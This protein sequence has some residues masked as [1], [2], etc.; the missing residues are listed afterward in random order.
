MQATTSSHN[1]QLKKQKSQLSMVLRE[2]AGPSQ[3]VPGQ[4][5]SS[6]IGTAK[7]QRNPVLKKQML[8]SGGTRL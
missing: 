8:G 1:E 4:S 6:R 7:W 3:W 2:E 5:T